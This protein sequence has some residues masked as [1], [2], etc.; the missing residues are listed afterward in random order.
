MIEQSTV[1]EN[2]RRQA[3][4]A[5][6]LAFMACFA[7]WTIF[8]IIGIKI[9]KELGLSDTERARVRLQEWQPI[10]FGREDAREGAQ[11]FVEKRA[12]SFVGR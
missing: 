6:T 10:V 7:V 9:Q 2:Q 8:S 12:P 5:S 1:S 11:A 3:L 4:G